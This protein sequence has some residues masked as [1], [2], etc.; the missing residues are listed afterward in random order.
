VVPRASTTPGSEL[1][2]CLKLALYDAWEE[3]T[4]HNLP[5]AKA[6]MGKRSTEERKAAIR[7]LAAELGVTGFASGPMRRP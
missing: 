5:P 3:A 6:L 7:V 4:P 2:R 1:R